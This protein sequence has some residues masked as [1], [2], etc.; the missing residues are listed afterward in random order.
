MKKFLVIWIT[1]GGAE[2]EERPSIIRTGL[3]NDVGAVNFF[4]S[5]EVGDRWD[6]GCG[7]VVRLKNGICARDS[8]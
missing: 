6:W 7:V 5:A 2:I 4:E 8:F 1:E 3:E